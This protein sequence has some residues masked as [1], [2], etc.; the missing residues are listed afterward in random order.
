[1]PISEV[2][3]EIMLVAGGLLVITAGIGLVRLQS[4]SGRSV[5]LR[6]E[7]FEEAGERV[8][9]GKEGIEQ[10]EHA[11]AEILETLGFNTWEEY[12]AGTERMRTLQHEA[13][14]AARSLEALRSAGETRQALE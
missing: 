10:A 2:I 5:R 11:L 3:A 6:E 12:Q 13:E 4:D 9:A 1:M 7:Q 14:S 8:R